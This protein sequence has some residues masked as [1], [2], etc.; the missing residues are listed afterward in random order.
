MMRAFLL[1][2]VLL[3]AWALAGRLV[4]RARARRELARRAAE[5]L[6]VRQMVADFTEDCRVAAFSAV[7]ASPSTWGRGE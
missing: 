6:Q 2:I 7:P 1:S 4:A 5:R 3:G